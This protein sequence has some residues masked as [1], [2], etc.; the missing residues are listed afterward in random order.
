M[1]FYNQTYQKLIDDKLQENPENTIETILNDEELIWKAY[2]Q[3]LMENSKKF[4]KMISLNRSDE[5]NQIVDESIQNVLKVFNDRNYNQTK[6]YYDF[7]RQFYNHF[8]HK[9]VGS[10]QSLLVK[11][12]KK[13]TTD[14]RRFYHRFLFLINFFSLINFTEIFIVDYF[15]LKKVSKW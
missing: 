14:L 1:F 7:V 8:E 10:S 5:S 3:T 12:Q 11:L 6:I 15:Y 4:L 2:N 13:F 9:I